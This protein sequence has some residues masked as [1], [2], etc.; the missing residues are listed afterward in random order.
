MLSA[1]RGRLVKDNTT[2]KAK[3]NIRNWECGVVIPVPSSALPAE[4]STDAG[5]RVADG[6][7]MSVFDGYIPVPVV[8]PG[9]EYQGRRPWFYSEQ[10]GN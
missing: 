9:E 3:I 7:D 2:K 1:S 4:T 10:Q 5:A 8:I 6:L